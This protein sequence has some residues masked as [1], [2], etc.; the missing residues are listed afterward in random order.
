[1]LNIQTMKAHQSNY[2]VGRKEPVKYIVLHYTANKGDRAES[3]CIYFASKNRNA[4]AHYFVDEKEIWSSVPEN[5]TAWHCGASLYTHLYCRNN[6]SI[7]I[8]MCSD[9]VNGN[10]VITDET[11]KNALELTKHIMEKY[12]IPIENVLRHYDVTGKICPEPWVRVSSKWNEFKEMLKG[13]NNM[14]VDEAKEIIKNKCGFDDNTMKYLEF[15][16][17]GDSL[18]TR[19]AQQIK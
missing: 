16:R 1:M 6:N 8:E 10:Y 18:I 19:I 17:Y 4:S 7:G 13:D 3:N 14:T 12:N 9:Y 11:I 2:T 15:Y 5:D